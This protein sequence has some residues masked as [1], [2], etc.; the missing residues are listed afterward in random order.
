MAL[1]S[2]FETI[3]KELMSWPGVT[4]GQH[5]FGGVEFRVGGREM[6]H[7]HGSSWADLPFPMNERNELLEKKRAS[8]HH[9]LPESGWVTFYIRSDEDVPALLELFKMQYSRLKR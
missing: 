6:G 4:S 1:A 3:E 8:P 9:V 7:L 2:R 5:R